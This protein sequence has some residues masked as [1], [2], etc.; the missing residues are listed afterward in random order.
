MDV[1]PVADTWVRPTTNNQ[2][3]D[4]APVGTA[5]KRNAVEE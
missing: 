2:M 1:V 3:V 4:G 5:E